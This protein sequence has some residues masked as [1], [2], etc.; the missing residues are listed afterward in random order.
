MDEN[1]GS[2]E[3]RW[4][5]RNQYMS[6]R[7]YF[8]TIISPGG[9]TTAVVEG[10]PAS[11]LERRRLNDAIMKQYRDVEQVGFLDRRVPYLQMAGGEFCGNATRCAA[12]LH[13]RQ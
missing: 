13:P 6:T 11:Q 2:E 10:I 8:V 4:G 7:N 5:K 3:Q 1:H 9:N 12:C